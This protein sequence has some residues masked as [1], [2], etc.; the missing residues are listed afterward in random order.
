MAQKIGQTLRNSI[1]KNRL[2]LSNDSGVIHFFM[3]PCNPV[4]FV[5]NDDLNTEFNIE[6]KFEIKMRP[7][8]LKTQR[9]RPVFPE[10]SVF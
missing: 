8:Y 3:K 9:C 1:K 7:F 5:K 6:S 4:F 2:F 10:V